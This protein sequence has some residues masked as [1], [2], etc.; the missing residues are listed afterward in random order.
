[1]RNWWLDGDA[2][3]AVGWPT[4]FPAS[5][6]DA[7]EPGLLIV[8]LPKPPSFADFSAVG[9]FVAAPRADSNGFPGDLGVLAEPNDAKAPE[10]RPKALDAPPMGDT[11]LP[12]G[13]MGP[14]EVFPSVE[15]SPPNRLKEEEELRPEGLS[16]PDPDVERESLLEL[17]RA[18]G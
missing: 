9:V 18:A 14:N 11:K 7:L 15:L 4:V 8:L 16:C 17:G 1:L 13:V 6:N 10:P 2:G 5:L 12:P 3:P